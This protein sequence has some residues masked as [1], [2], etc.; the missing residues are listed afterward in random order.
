MLQ[1]AGGWCR[2]FF[3]LHRLL[4]LIFLINYFSHG[5]RDFNINC[6]CNLKRGIFLTTDYFVL[7]LLP[8]RKFLLSRATL[9]G[10]YL[11]LS[12]GAKE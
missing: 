2:D 6:N 1:Y 4:H 8:C 10:Y 9:S 7:K 5:D 11:S 12:K 3:L